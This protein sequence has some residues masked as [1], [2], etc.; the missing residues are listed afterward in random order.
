SGSSLD[1]EVFVHVGAQLIRP[2]L[3]D[4][5][6]IALL[7]KS[8]G[9]GGDETALEREHGRRRVEEVHRH[10]PAT[11]ANGCERSGAGGVAVLIGCQRGNARHTDA[12]RRVRLELIRGIWL[13]VVHRIL[14]EAL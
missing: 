1:L 9:T 6:T 11:Q 3:V 5:R 13:S 12:A 2:D 14:Q 8:T 10:D 7:N 4:R